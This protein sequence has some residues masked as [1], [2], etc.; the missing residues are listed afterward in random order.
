M[1][2]EKPKR[3][4]GLIL[5]REGWQKLQDAKLE[6]EFR[7]NNG[8]KSTL[9][10]LS[11]QA[12]ITPV[13]FRKILTRE[14][15]VDKR[16]LVRLF[17]MFNLELDV[18]DYISPDSNLKGQ[19]N[20]KNPKRVDWGEMVDV[21]VFY[22]RTDELTLLEQW[23][24]QERC[25]V[26][27]LLGMGG[28]GKTSLA[29]KLSQ[30]VQGWFE[31]VIWRS[32]Y[33]AP[34]LFDLLAN[35][36][37]FFSNEQVLE[38]DL[39]KSVD[40][41]ISQLI[42]YLQ[43]QRCLIVL[44][45]VE[46]ILQTGAYAGCYREGYEDYGLLIKRLGQVMHQSSLVL[47]SREKPKDIASLGG[48]TLAVRSLQLSGLEV[49]AGQ[50]IF[51]AK[52]FSV[53][54]SEL[55]A[56]VERYAGNALALKIVATTIQDVF[57]GNVAEFLQHYT[58][59]FGSIRDLLDQQFSRLANLEKDIIYWLAINRE[60]V[61]LSVI[62]EDIVSPIPPQNLLEALESL[63]R[64]SLVEKSTALFT[65]QP[66]VMEYVT[67]RLIEIVCQEIETQNLDLFRCHA[68][69]KATA[70]DYVRE[71][72]IR[73][74]LKPVIDGLVTVLRSKRN[75][76]NQ[77]TEIIAKSRETS[78]LE[79]SYTAGNVL[80]LLCY[81]GTDLSGY[82]FSFLSVWQADLRNVKLHD[83]NFQNANFD[84]S[85]F[86]ET[87]G[88]VSS[89]AFS[90]DGKLL[91]MGDTGGEIHFYQVSDWK[92]LL[93]CKGHTN[94]IPSLAFSPDGS[95]LASG[96]SD[97]TVRLWDIGR[98]R[99]LQ[100][101]QK[102]SNEIWS[103]AFSPDGNTLVSASNDRT[104]RLWDVSTGEC[105][106]TFSG[107]TNWV[108][109]VAFSPNGQTL[110]SG[111]DDNTIRLWDI[112]S[113]EC[114]R[115]LHGHDDGVR[116]I[117]FSPDGQILVSSSDDRTVKLWDLNTGECIKSL[118]GHRAP[119]WSSAISP[120][121]NFI[122][123][124]SLDQTVRLWNISTG[125]CLRTLEGHSGWVL[126]VAFNLQSD[127]L[128][129]SSDDQTIKVWNVST[130]Q[131]L[132][133]FIGY[134]S[135]SWSVA[136]NSDRRT[137]ASGSQDRAVRLWDINTGKALQTFL[138]HGGAVRSVAF[139]RD[140]QMLI[141]GSDDR[142]MRLW[143]VNTGQ[144]LQTF[145]GHRAAVTSVA[146]SQ[147]G[148]MLVSGSDDQT[149]RLWDVNTGQA[150]QTLL[151]HHA[152]VAS[153][154]FSPD[155]RTAASGGWDHTI[156]LWD[157]STGECKETLKGHKNW[158]W[159][160]AFSPDGEL[161]ASGGYDGTI[162]LWS[163]KNSTCFKIFKVGENNSIVK[164]V[165]FSEDGQTLA[166]SSPDHTIKLW[167]LSTGECK[168]TLRGH[169]AFVWSVAF[170]LDNQTL[171]S[172]STDDT[173]RLWNVSASECLKILKPKK[174]YE[175][176]NIQ[177]VTGITGA[178]ISMLKLLGAVTSENSLSNS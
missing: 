76:E 150:L 13:T 87:F 62:R 75:L 153:V 33:N 21:S 23:L 149:V 49:V 152:A 73:V 17:M 98:G 164:T 71:T 52:G 88:G 139:S 123:S 10:E 151:G 35:L 1:K 61:S 74:I 102:H 45:N 106:R 97:Y 65:L 112:S 53:S 4:R 42:E 147:S 77:L 155:G 69:M 154:A 158:V 5:T 114:K 60:P 38:I 47:T 99:C 20:L 9:E 36:I 6:W 55:P 44:D 121:G 58:A 8:S 161:L 2:P 30:K 59:V 170:S 79:H 83:V 40:G 156:K 15:G 86:A 143:D 134:T 31:Y 34:P 128:A 19:E 137:L 163:V 130:G 122:A 78:P 29:A 68:L 148:Q 125:E 124:G 162:R 119:V 141:S 93:T 82:D 85:V 16:T 172:S 27:A 167:D 160:I 39:A 24:I 168:K 146:F 26:V 96:S 92:H 173:I 80:N 111:S 37:Q 120:Q 51:E 174:L 63:V 159:S 133:T 126:S 89:V 157:V 41:R 22:G 48:E 91:A 56:V 64:R 175:G 84:R 140:G 14:T 103:V 138:R 25:R 54:E 50:K 110:A 145:L 66:V 171:A 11:E 132:K 18:S 166:S 43:Q 3:N 70:K 135:H 108:I 95:I 94:W 57:D 81:L 113:D 118:H 176:T 100:T 12:G 28:I 178:T 101:F 32:L 72:Q 105:L 104:I 115:I 67:Q 169:S 117:T 177:E 131:C 144:A 7:K 136:F 116:S 142:T 127:L 129:S 46:T 107:H 165:A 109:S 90:P